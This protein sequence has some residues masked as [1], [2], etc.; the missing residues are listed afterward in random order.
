[1]LDTGAPETPINS[2]ATRNIKAGNRCRFL[3][4][5]RIERR[6]GLEL[7]LRAF[8]IV[9][10]EGA[11]NWEFII[12]GEGPDR[13]RL[14]TL[15]RDMQLTGQIHFL[16]PVPHHEVQD[17]FRNADVFLFTSVRDTSGGVN[18]EAMAAGLPVLCIAHQGVADITDESC[19][20]RIPPASVADTISALA[21]G[22]R[23]FTTQPD[24]LV[25]LSKAAKLRAHNHFSW[26]AKFDR[27]VEVYR[28]ILQSR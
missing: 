14:E 20:I 28:E 27:M 24:L 8:D 3:Y 5:G 15:A 21:A 4:A 23:K 12:L 2:P 17:H 13:P 22:I 11:E 6:K 19:A 9:R 18:L 26:G 7:A 25:S 10:R 1:M 16:N